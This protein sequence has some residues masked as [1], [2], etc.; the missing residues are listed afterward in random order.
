MLY[1]RTPSNA[2]SLRCAKKQY[3]LPTPQGGREAANIVLTE[4]QKEFTQRRA[5]TRKERRAENAFDPD[6]SVGFSAARQTAQGP[7][8]GFGRRNPN[9]TKGRTG[10]KKS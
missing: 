10:R 3:P 6:A 4:D 2:S 9:E 8:V 1:V 5:R 7:P